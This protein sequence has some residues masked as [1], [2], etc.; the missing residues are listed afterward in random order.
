MRNLVLFGIFTLALATACSKKETPSPTTTTSATATASAAPT[1]TAS[2][3]PAA[4]TA[5]APAVEVSPQMKSFMDMLDGSDG[6]AG[7]A[8]KKFGEPS[9]QKNDVG[10][11]SLKNPK[12][13]KAERVGVMQCY[14][15]ESEAGV[16]HH[17][18]R[19]CWDTKGKI[20]Q[21]T[22]KSS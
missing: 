1:T 18:T 12:V 7:K 10:M 2:A 19:V 5:A 11:Y 8:L 13:T 15:M 14:T 9:V 16:M 6:S 17:E 20:A 21:I 3:T 22:D 4:T